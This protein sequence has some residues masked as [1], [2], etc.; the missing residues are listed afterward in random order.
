MATATQPVS[1]NAAYP[2]DAVSR[3]FA[4]PE[5]EV[6]ALKLRRLLHEARDKGTYLHTAGAYDAFTSAIMPKLG[7]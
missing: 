2:A 7:F 4:P 3:L 6:P 5:P 1:P